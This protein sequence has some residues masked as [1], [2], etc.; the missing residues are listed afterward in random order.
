MNNLNFHGFVHINK[1]INVN[2]YNILCHGWLDY[3]IDILTKTFTIYLINRYYTNYSTKS[4]QSHSCE[5]FFNPLCKRTISVLI[6]DI[7]NTFYNMQDL[8]S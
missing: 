8:W 6:A 1:Y 7:L 4:K 3:C 2:H 5:R